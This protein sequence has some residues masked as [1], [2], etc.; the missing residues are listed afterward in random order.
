VSDDI[1]TVQVKESPVQVEPVHPFH[2]APAPGTA[3]TVTEVPL[4]KLLPEG[5]LLADPLPLVFITSL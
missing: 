4:A 1:V 2:V 3:V 5:L